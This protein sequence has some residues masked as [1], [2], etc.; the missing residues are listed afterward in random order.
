MLTGDA[1][2]VKKAEEQKKAKKKTKGKGGK[3]K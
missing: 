3:K 2:T 1:E